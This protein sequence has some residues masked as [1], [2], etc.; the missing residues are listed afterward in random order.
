VLTGR[1]NDGSSGLRAIKRCGGIAVVQDPRDAEHPDMPRNALDAVKA[2][3]VVALAQLPALLV[4]LADKPAGRRR[5]APDDVRLEVDIAA[6]GAS[7]LSA[8][9]ALG[10]RSL[11]ACPTC[12]GILWEIKDGKEIRYR[13][14]VGHAFTADTLDLALRDDLSRALASA[15]RALEE[16]GGL[17]R[18][19]AQEARNMDRGKM[20]ESWDS[21][22]RSYEEQARL[23]RKVLWE[24]PVGASGIPPR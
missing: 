13:C 5:R 24:R 8:N 12:R 18:R 20:A 15:V 7:D 21:K 16:R 17:M 3:H 11:F 2:D 6:R 10:E 1:L 14:H 19:L 4:R 23:V 9:D 22:A